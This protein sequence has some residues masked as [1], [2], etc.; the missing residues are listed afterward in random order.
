MI[1]ELLNNALNHSLSHIGAIVA[2]Q[3][4]PNLKKIQLCVVDK[5]VG[6]LHNIKRK[7]NVSSESE[8]ILKAIEKGVSCPPPKLYSSS[9]NNA[10]Y[11]LF[12]LTEI[13]KHTRGRLKIISN[14]GIVYIDENNE[15]HLKDNISSDWK[16]SIVVFELYEKNIN[17][18]KDEFFRIYIYQDNEDTEDIFI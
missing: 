18:S 3:Y 5:G 15:I 2:G 7:Y 13:I 1:S 11:G 8:A 12:V 4:F 9:V 6:F 10:G 16:G 14:D 17:F